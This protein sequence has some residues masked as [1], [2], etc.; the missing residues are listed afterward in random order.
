M[1]KI[2][3]LFIP[4]LLSTIHSNNQLFN[5]QPTQTITMAD[6]SDPR[7]E[8]Y[9]TASKT[10]KQWK[11][12]LAPAQKRMKTG[13]FTKEDATHFI[14]HSADNR[15][16]TDIVFFYHKQ[17]SIMM[18]FN[19]AEMSAQMQMWRT[20][21]RS[22]KLKIC[23]YNNTEHIVNGKTIYALTV[24]AYNGD[25]IAEQ[26][27]DAI[28]LMAFGVLVSGCTYYFRTKANRD[29]VQKYVMKP[30]RAKTSEFDLD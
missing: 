28:H 3:Q 23:E 13:L 24:Q 15:V 2:E 7:F 1:Q 20:Q 21:A 11:A 17:M 29:A 6:Y 12:L 8:L 14:D 22:G 25:E 4:L 27:T 18:V 19:Q 30:P 16:K 5:K 10:G 9:D 26:S